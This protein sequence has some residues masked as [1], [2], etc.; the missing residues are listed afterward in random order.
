MVK[1]I[2]TPIWLGTSKQPFWALFSELNLSFLIPNKKEPVSLEVSW[3]VA[4][5]TNT[6]RRSHFQIS[7]RLKYR[8]AIGKTHDV[9]VVSQHRGIQ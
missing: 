5:V 4:E 2:V 8:L 3:E 9:G 6:A 1:F 7:Q